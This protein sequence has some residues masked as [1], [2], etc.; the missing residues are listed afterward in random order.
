M[1]LRRSRSAVKSMQNQ[2]ALFRSET[3]TLRRKVKMETQKRKEAETINESLMKDYENLKRYTKRLENGYLKKGKIKTHRMD[4]AR[5][6][7]SLLKYITFKDVQLWKTQ[8]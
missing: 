2:I 1:I 3:E 8:V 6:V 4:S 7:I 5:Q